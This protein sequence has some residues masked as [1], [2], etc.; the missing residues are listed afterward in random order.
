MRPLLVIL[1]AGFD[2]SC[3]A[4][5]PLSDADLSAF[6]QLQAARADQFRS[7]A[8][9]IDLRVN[10]SGNKFSFS[11]ELYF[12]GDSV[13]FYGR[14]YFGK[15]A[16]KGTII[17]GL[18]TLYLD[19]RNEYFVTREEKLLTETACAEPGEVLLYMLSLFSGRHRAGDDLLLVSAAK[20]TARYLDGRFAGTVSLAGKQRQYPM[21]EWLVSPACGDSITLAYGSFRSEFPF[22]Q[23]SEGR[24]DNERQDFH[25]RGFVREQRY[26]IGLPGKKFALEIPA[27]AVRVDKLGR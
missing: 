9:L 6:R 18:V 19:G 11:T 13:G 8:Y 2:L 23:I 12:S 3:S 22:Y 21:R 7:A 17:D 16:F 14:G 25:V 4:P 1:A 26:N 27:D 15:G 10:D 20:R 5:P 24:Y